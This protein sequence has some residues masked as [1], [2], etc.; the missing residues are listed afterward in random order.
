MN[1]RTFL[2][3]SATVPLLAGSTFALGDGPSSRRREFNETIEAAW[4][5]AMEVLKPTPKQL[6]HGLALHADAIVCESYGFSPRSALDV[7]AYLKVAEAGGTTVELQDLKEEMGMTRCV[8]NL[9]QR[10][11]YREAW[12]AAGVTCI[13]Q[14]AG[15]ESQAPLR[16]IKRL[17][18]FTYVTDM[19]GDIV[20][21][22]AKPD[23]I[24]AAKKQGK[25]CLYFSSNGVPLAEQWGSVEEELAYVRVFFQLGIRMMHITYNRRNMLGDGCAEPA[26]GGLSDFGRSAVAEMN[27]V[28][29]IPDVAHSGWQTSFDTAK[30]SQRPVVA[31]HTTCDG[32]VH[33]IRAKPDNVIKAIADSG[34]TIGIC[35][36]SHFL[37][38]SGDLGAML[39]HI[40]YAVRRFGAERVTIG[41]DI[42]YSARSQR[43]ESKKM[44]K[45]GPTHHRWE[46]FWPSE[47]QKGPSQHASL[48]WTNWPAFTIGMVQ[49]GHSD[50]DIR[51]ILGENVLRVARSTLA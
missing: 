27:R 2:K 13:L 18:R 21:K 41:T 4:N 15:E 26:N 36:I 46:N 34:G 3:A 43:G 16:I 47:S 20:I 40:D 28:R 50:D 11:E 48:A 42:A 38:G 22:A 31:S 23:D 8:T 7:D 14:N 37:G 17:A 1:R 45:A 33:H 6:Q 49:R 30:A 32:L 19:L 9:A 12:E 35:A 5:A 39:D 51:K 10:A 24:V 44:P 29:V 25:H